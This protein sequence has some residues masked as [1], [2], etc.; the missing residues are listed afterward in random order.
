M[1]T[2]Y[3]HMLRIAPATARRLRAFAGEHGQTMSAAIDALLDAAKFP[4]EH[5]MPNFAWAGEQDALERFHE[6]LRAAEAAGDE[7]LA[8]FARKRLSQIDDALTGKPQESE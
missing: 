3:T 1:P 2:K 5:V 6:M 7:P 8:D 4:K